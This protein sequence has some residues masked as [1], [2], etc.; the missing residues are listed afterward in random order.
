MVKPA[1]TA[2]R[3]PSVQQ[4]SP[5][6]G[7]TRPLGRKARRCPGDAGDAIA[8]P[9]ESHDASNVVGHCED[10]PVAQYLGG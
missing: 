1:E 4:T 5:T 7:E 8:A 3:S 10:H 2:P 6:T 9:E